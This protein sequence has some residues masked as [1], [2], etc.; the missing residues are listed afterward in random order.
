M[1]GANR[2][3]TVS[4]MVLALAFMVVWSGISFAERLPIKSYTTADGLAQNSVNRIVRDSRG[5]LWFCTE[6]GLSRYDGYTFTN[7]GVEQGLQDGHVRDLLE[8]REGEYWVATLGGL[9]RFNPRG[10]R[11]PVGADRLPQNQQTEGVGRRTTDDPMFALIRTN[12]HLGTG[13]MNVL[14]QDHT[15]T[16]WC[17]AGRG[18]YQLKQMDGEWT[19]RLIEIG[20]PREVENDMR[21]L[22]LAEDR[23]GVLWIGA[24]SGL[25]RRWPDGRA[26]RYTAEHGL[27]GNEVRALLVDTN[28]QLWAGTREGLS[29]LALEPGARRPRIIRVYNTKNGLRNPN[30]RSLFQSSTGQLWVG[31]STAL[32]GFIP[33][34]GGNDALFRY[35]VSELGLSKLFVQTLTE[36]LDGNL[37]IGTDNGAL[38]LARNG[39][40]TY[41]EDD[42][43]GETRVS[44]LFESQAGTIGALTIFSSATP[45]SWFE[46]SGFR[47]IRP[48][49]PRRLTYFGWGWHQ[50]TLQDQA[51]EWW[52]PTGQGLVRYPKVNHVRQLATTRPKAIYTTKDGL[53]SNDV[54]RLYQDSR[55]DIWIATFSEAGSGITRWERATGRLHHYGEADGLPRRT[56]IAYAFMDDRSGNLWIGLETDALARFRDGRFTVFTPDQ[57]LPPGKIQNLYLDHAGRLWMASSVS[58]LV[59]LDDTSADRPQFITYTTMDGLSSNSINCITEDGYGR[60][61]L[62]TAR[63]L[64]RLDPATGRVKPFTSADGLIS[65]EVLVSFRDRR[66]DLWF[67]GKGGLS[68]LSPQPDPPQSPPPVLI[69]GLRIGGESHQISAI[70]EREIGPVELGPD[71]IQIQIDFVALGFSPGE[72]LRYQY[73]L[74]GSSEDWSQL[75][76]HRTV[77]FARLAHGRYRFLVRAINADGVM[78]EPPASFSFRVLPPIWQRW[79][80]VAMVAT[81]VGLIAYAL[82]RYRVAR[83]LEIE[84]VRTRIASDLHDDIGSNLTKIAIL[85]EVAQQQFGREETDGGPLSSVARI[86]RESLDSMG[87][88]VWAINPKRDSLREL[89]RRLRGFATDIFTSRNIELSFQAIDRNL[90]LKLGP[91]TRRNIFLIFKEAVNNAVR[92]SECSKAEIELK[93]VGASLVMTVRDDGKGFDLT[94]AGE[95]NGLVSMRRRAESMQGVLDVSSTLGKGS[96]VTLTTPI[97]RRH[98]LVAKSN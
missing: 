30:T 33:Q 9:C 15:G 66:G 41:T 38:K 14:L 67:G 10:C 11:S 65:G 7:Y 28:G 71:K 69:T 92:H 78:S 51:G 83:F 25:Y 54:F 46:G 47:S 3:K 62:G 63:G 48:R 43:L 58:G 34:A 61:Y 31:L 20:L 98:S 74:E 36:D 8:T 23:D 88:I 49:L 90:E 27:A 80:F 44:A 72:G 86:S 93:V 79:W 21:V 17:G 16:V 59:R 50:L 73:K 22:A 84:R 26:E 76:D 97:G 96:S 39:F 91:D 75:A 12:D 56:S 24:G 87:D 89:S 19:L 42:G 32:V 60:L 53:I 95:G 37:W 13:S 40:T 94:V 1:S 55:G 6:D 64:D 18:L 35:Y 45:I 68:R 2:K 85:T 77:N 52:F 70:G 29:Q 4:L 81:L 57:G 5:F 82:Y